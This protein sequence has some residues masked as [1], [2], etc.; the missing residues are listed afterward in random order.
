MV[1]YPFKDNTEMANTGKIGEISFPCF[2][3]SF[4][5]ITT[6]LSLFYRGI[7]SPLFRRMPLLGVEDLPYLTNKVNELSF[8]ET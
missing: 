6:Q 3:G 4:P 2:R 5:F 7:E 8:S 1:D